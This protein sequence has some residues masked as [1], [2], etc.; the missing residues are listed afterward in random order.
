MSRKHAAAALVTLTLI[1]LFMAKAYY[2][3]NTIEVQQYQIKKSALCKV[4]AGLKVAH[5]SDLHIQ[6]I[7]NREK[8]IFEIL[9]QEK[10]DLIFLTGDYIKFNG[11]YDPVLSFIRQLKAPFGV[12]AVMGNTEYYN[13]NG[14]C[15]LCHKEGS[16]KIKEKPHPVFLRNSHI[17]LKINGKVIT[18]LGVDD[19][20]NERND[21]KQSLKG[22]SFGSPVI[23]LAHSPEIFPEASDLGIGLVLSGHTHGGQ[24]RGIKYLKNIFPLE[25]AL[26]FLDGFFQ[27]GKTL[28]YVNRGIGTSF[29]PFRLGVKPEVTFLSF[30]DAT[31]SSNLPDYAQVSYYGSPKKIFSGL[32]PGSLVE[33][34]NLF[35]SFIKKFFPSRPLNECNPLFDFE[36]PEDLTRLNWECHKWFELSREH[37]TSGKYSLKASFPPGQYPGIDFQGIQADW[38]PYVSFKMD[39]F[40]PSEEKVGFH[41]RIDDHKSDW[42]YANRFDLDVALKPGVNTIS[43]PTSSIKT[44]LRHRPLNLKKIERLIVFLPNNRNPRDL[45]VDN[46]RLN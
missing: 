18:V 32:D 43:I 1:V 26:K 11:S 27:K 46:I 41:I 9:N 29:L 10:P 24:I 2:D 4:L 44:N 20:V 13:E 39:I 23:L 6:R 17:D 42:E 15:V 28:M 22:V 12:Y 36:S 33:T 16:K 19:P 38:S 14:S 8:K 7:T 3:T 45:Y 37:V 31:D 30:M 35:D 21:L 34:F 5:L 25:P 40:N